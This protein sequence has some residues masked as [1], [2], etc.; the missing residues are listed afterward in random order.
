MPC[1]RWILG[2]FCLSALFVAPGCSSDEAQSCASARDCPSGTTCVSNRCTAYDGVDG[3]PQGQ[4]SGIGRDAQPPPTIIGLALEPPSVELIARDGDRPSADFRIV[5]SYSD[6]STRNLPGGSFSVTP[7]ALGSIDTVGHFVADG[8]FGGQGEIEVEAEGHSATASIRIRLET[9]VFGE[10]VTADVLPRF[11]IPAIDD[12]IREA[13][14]LYPLDGTVMPQNVYPADVQWQTSTPGDLYRVS[15]E[16]PNATL[17]GYVAADAGFRNGWLADEFGWRRLAQSDPESPAAIRVDRLEAASGELIRGKPVQMRFA[18]AALTG[19]VYYWDI[20]AGRIIRIDDGTNNRQ[21]FMPSPPLGCVGCHSVSSSG[22]YMAGR[23]GG[24][25]NIASVFDLTKDLTSDPPPLEF[26]TS[27]SM[28]WWFSSWSPDDTRLVVSLTEGAPST[29]GLALVDPK[30]GTYV[31]PVEGALPTGLATHPAWA[32]DGNEIAYVGN[33]DVWGG[34]N[35]TG[36]IRAL[37]VLGPDRIGASRLLVAGDQIP[38][39]VPAG[40]AASYPSYSP[41]SRWLAFAHGTSSRS[42]TGESAL[43]FLRRDGTGLVRLDNASGGPNGVT[44]FQPRFS[45]FEQDGYY[46]LSFLSRRDYG[47]PIAGTAGTG[48][49]QIWV[50]AIKTN[51]QPGEDP[52]TVP[53]WLPG[54]S[55]ASL[56]IS[57]YWAPR[58]CREGGASC[59]VGAECC[60][61]VCNADTSGAICTDPPSG[62]CAQFGEA[63]TGDGDCCV[64]LP[65]GGGVC[66][67]F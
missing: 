47:N 53:Y 58:P 7:Y 11:A 25:E 32:P 43:Y 24:G 31:S 49:Q 55:T 9:V 19:S 2:A 15:I 16:K 37:E 64:G 14:L 28:R 22:R 8:R 62:G 21:A 18:R 59:A 54:Q 12:P 27:E 13:T 23:F 66:G 56:N 46:W 17:I 65:C 51:P 67:G 30:T 41:D 4:D 52:S 57:A 35:T 61:Q 20:G 26:P 63:C 38:G 10:G 36:D 44:S 48:R 1:M 60:S 5:A 6:G 33:L 39:A 42:E 45:P 34:A 3:G 40:R 29:A 50:A